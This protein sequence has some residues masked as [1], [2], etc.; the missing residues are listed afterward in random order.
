MI[1]FCGEQR[2]ARIRPGASFRGRT[3][4]IDSSLSSENLH[5][6]K[7]AADESE[8]HA[9][10]SCVETLLNTDDST[11]ADPASDPLPI[12]HYSVCVCLCAGRR[13]PRCYLPRINI[14][15]QKI[16]SPKAGWQKRE[17]RKETP[18]PEAH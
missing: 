17:E 14:K 1:I 15:G 13:T 2:S 10:V 18:A 4:Q 16:V 11:D 9:L 12:M 5:R 8:R 3:E 7:H 6:V